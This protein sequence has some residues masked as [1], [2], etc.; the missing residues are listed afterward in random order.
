MKML[1]KAIN[2]H[3]TKLGSKVFRSL[4][5]FKKKFRKINQAES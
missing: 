2:F 1:V 3:E 4:R 5:L